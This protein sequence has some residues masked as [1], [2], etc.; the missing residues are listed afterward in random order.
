MKKLKQG[1]Q[2]F[3]PVCEYFFTG[4]QIRKR[5]I[6]DKEYAKYMFRI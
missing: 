3:M 1:R 6:Q 4:K 5:G 2:G